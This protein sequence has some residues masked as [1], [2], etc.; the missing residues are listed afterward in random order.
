MQSDIPLSEGRGPTETAFTERKSSSSSRPFVVFS[1]ACSN[2]L[3]IAVD[4]S[5]F[6]HLCFLRPTVGQIKNKSDSAEWAPSLHSIATSGLRAASMKKMPS[7]DAAVQSSASTRQFDRVLCGRCFVFA[8][9]GGQVRRTSDPSNSANVAPRP[10]SSPS[11]VSCL[12]P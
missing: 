1:I 8:L 3:P 7:G 10:I 9:L 11:L 6:A 5:F 4:K 2:G 12:L